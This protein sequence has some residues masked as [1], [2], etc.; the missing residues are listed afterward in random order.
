MRGADRARLVFAVAIFA[1]VL[2]FGQTHPLTYQRLRGHRAGTQ[3]GSAAPRIT[4]SKPRAK[5]ITATRAGL[6][7]AVS[8]NLNLE[9]AS[10]QPT[11]VFSLL[12]VIDVEN[13][14]ASTNR[15]RSGLLGFGSVV[16]ELQLVQG[17]QHL[18]TQ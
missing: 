6:L 1:P 11:N 4:T 10:G 14:G 13:N 15:S 17:R 2:A 5:S 9:G 16:A 12:N 7:P 8:G 18:R 3:P